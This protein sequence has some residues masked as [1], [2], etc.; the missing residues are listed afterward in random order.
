MEHEP[1]IIEQYLE[2]RFL[3]YFPDASISI[4]EADDDDE[5]TTV[6]VSL[7]SGTQWKY[8]CEPGSDDDY[9]SFNEVSQGFSLITV[10]FPLGGFC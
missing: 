8:V 4:I 9:F 7:P 10:P 3:E 6:I 1:V 2:A 5:T